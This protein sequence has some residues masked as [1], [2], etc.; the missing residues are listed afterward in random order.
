M[1]AAGQP[2]VA[3]GY[4]TVSA[5]DWWAL[6]AVILIGHPA[7]IGAHS[8]LFIALLTCASTVLVA[9]PILCKIFFL[10]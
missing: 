3:P 5:A 9:F 10:R 8:E 7:D 2:V 4:M 1:Q 6:D